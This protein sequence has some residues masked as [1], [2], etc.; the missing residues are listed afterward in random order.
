MKNME[1]TQC[2]QNNSNQV[3][4]NS[5]RIHIFGNSD[6]KRYHYFKKA[7]TEK[8]IELIFWS[9][10]DENPLFYKTYN[11]GE[12]IK[13]DPPV[14]ETSEINQLNDLAKKYHETLIKLETIKDAKFL[15]T[16]SSIWKTLDKIYCKK[17]LQNCNIATTPILQGD[18]KDYTSL[19]ESMKKSKIYKVFIKPRY[20]SGAAGI[21]AYKW[22]PNNDMEILETCLKTENNIFFNTKNLFRYSKNVDIKNLIDFILKEDAIVEH[23]IPKDV[24]K[25]SV[26]D[27][28]VVYQYGKIDF[29]VG[30]GSKVGAITN[31]HLNNEVIDIKALE[32]SQETMDEIA[33][34]CNLIAQKFSGLNSFGVDILLTHKTRKPI[35]IEVNG[36][37]DLIYKDILNENKI[38]KT[39]I[40]NLIIE[41]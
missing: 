29:I 18:Y 10:Q 6:S 3:H 27:L 11:A 19:K 12:P 32:L 38:Y 41:K 33:K 1:I 23:W 9:I 24:Y 40:A 25:N 17:Q 30:R 39:Q 34:I 5:K 7:C 31:L 8:D 4:N 13:I 22:N 2:L 26:Y 36:Q 20:G 35:V 14:Y 37:G 15:N 16:P 21:M 28:R